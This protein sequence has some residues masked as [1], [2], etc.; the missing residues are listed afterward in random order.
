MKLKCFF[1][2]TILFFGCQKAIV[3]TQAQARAD[4]ERFAVREQMVRDAEMRRVQQIGFSRLATIK[5]KAQENVKLVRKDDEVSFKYK[6]TLTNEDIKAVTI[7]PADLSQFKEFLRQPNTGVIRLHSA[8]NCL[9]ESRVIQAVGTCPNNIIGKATSYSFRTNDY[10]NILFSDIF[11]IKNAFSSTGAFT[12]GI[13]SNLGNVDIKTLT[14]LSEG[15]RQLADFQPSASESDI[16]RHFNV[17]KKGIQIGDNIYK[18]STASA[19]NSVYVLRTIA[20]KG[21][22]I[23]NST[24]NR[25]NIL[26]GDERKDVLLV[27]QV[28]R[29]HEDGSLTLLYKELRRKD[30]PKVLLEEKK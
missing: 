19:E 27:F 29:K 8:D 5:S 12:L 23:R 21:R 7:H 16:E 28:V 13:F 25:I 30:V 20:Y 10:V 15:V 1:L 18:T 17:L 22:I 26:D 9:P 14:L 24:T 4:Q 3:Q 2:L 11:F 6:P